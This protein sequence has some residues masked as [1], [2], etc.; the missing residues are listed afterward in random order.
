MVFTPVITFTDGLKYKPRRTIRVEIYQNFSAI[1]TI[2][3]SLF[4]PITFLHN[5]CSHG[6]WKCH[7]FIRR[8]NPLINECC[9]RSPSP[10]TPGFLLLTFVGVLARKTKTLHP[11]KPCNNNHNNYLQ[12]RLLKNNAFQKLRYKSTCVTCNTQILSHINF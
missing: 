11:V 7:K 2:H 9:N 4:K 5:S 12:C 6:F 1:K 8:C 3:N 10:T